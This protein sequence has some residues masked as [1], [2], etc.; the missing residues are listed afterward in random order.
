M[1]MV[2]GFSNRMSIDVSHG[3]SRYLNDESMN[4]VLGKSH[5]EVQG[6]IQNELDS[7][8]QWPIHEKCRVYS[9]VQSGVLTF[10]ALIIS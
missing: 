6:S 2:G 5:V 8:L 3:S 9:L 1:Q 7:T 10:H 4:F